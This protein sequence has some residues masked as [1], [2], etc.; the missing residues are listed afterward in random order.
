M[1]FLTPIAFIG[2]LVAIPILLLYMLRLRR[3]EVVVS[4]NFLWGQIIQD[5]EA[6]T[7]W[8]RLRRNLLLLLQLLILACLVL[9]LARPFITVPSVSSGKTALLLDAS[10]S[11]NATDENG[12]T[13]WEVARERALDIINAMGPSDTLSLILVGTIAEPLTPYT[14]DVNELRAALNAASPTVGRGDWETALIIAAAGAAGAEN[15]NIIIISDG[16]IGDVGALGASLPEPIYLPVGQSASNIGLSAL[17]V[18]SQAGNTSQLFAQVVNYGPVPAETSLVIKF[19]GVPT[20]SRTETIAPDSRH[21]FVFNIAQPFALIEAEVI[22]RADSLDYLT[23]DNIGWIIRRATQTRRILL[24]SEEN[25]FIE[26]VLR[27]LPNVQLFRGDITRPTLP[28]QTYDVYIFNNYLPDTLPQGDMFIINPPSDTPLFTV[29]GTTNAANN[30]ITIQNG[31]P[32]VAFVDFDTVNIRN[33][34]IVR[35]SGWAETLIAADGGPLLLA[36]VESGRQIAL[37]S[38]DVRDSD[39]PL[40]IS[41]PILIA[42]LMEWFTPSDIIQTPNTLTIGSAVTIRPPVDANRVRVALPDGQ[43]RDF[44]IVGDTLTFA[45]S[46]QLGIYEVSAYRDETPLQSA[47][48]AVNFF[49]TD[50]SNIAPVAVEDLRFGGNPIQANDRSE[51]S[52]REFWPWAAFF[53]LVILLIEWYVYHQR[54][55]VPTLFSASTRRVEQRPAR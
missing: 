45:E 29:G 48:F 31:N 12:R 41:W 23:L 28:S 39:L 33:F 49:A 14:N 3:R 43:T 50:E 5:K 20:L 53:G 21:D 27:S 38:F 10:A 47:L 4:S 2:A 22:P 51:I 54:L 30:I 6:N 8:Q 18:A 46:N 13:R 17:A 16:R 9:A 52:Q 19:D 24:L 35:D 44:P 25:I 11:M 55:R 34:K 37:L 42:N 15:F 40:Q 36:G 7:P 1:Q 32:L 26:Q